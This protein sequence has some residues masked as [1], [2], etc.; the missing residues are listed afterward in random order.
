M[1]APTFPTRDDLVEAWGDTVLGILPGRARARFRVGRFVA[2][3]DGTAVFSLPNATHR[4]Y[5]EEVRREV[6]DVLSGHFGLAV[7]LRLVVDADAAG[8]AAEVG[9]GGE[10][11]GGISETVP[12][13]PRRGEPDAGAVGDDDDGD[14]LDPENLAE[15]TSPAGATLS[16]ADR[17]KQA[18]PGAEEI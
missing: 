10:T 8:S 2:A 7:P 13:D 4:S 18:F 12:T 14:L 17:L 1:A 6:E 15:Q 5:C 16:A 3:E 11:G 9:S